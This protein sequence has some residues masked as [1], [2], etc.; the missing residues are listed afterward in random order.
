MTLTATVD[1]SS[2]TG[3]IT[4]YDGAVVLGTSTLSAGTAV[5]FVELNAT[6][7][8][9]MTA[10]YPGDGQNSPALSSPATVTVSSVSA[11]GFNSSNLDVGRVPF[12]TAVGDFNND[13]IPHL[14]TVGSGNSVH[15]GRRLRRDGYPD[16]LVTNSAGNNVTVLRN[17]GTGAFEGWQVFPLGLRLVRDGGRFQWGWKAGFCCSQQ[18]KRQLERVARKR[19]PHFPCGDELPNFA[20]TEDG[21]RETLM[22]TARWIWQSQVTTTR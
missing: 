18:R 16:L 20:S 13:G 14:V 5:L 22:V 1:P 10:R 6:G 19:E 3:K 12:A 4:F 11:S 8:L 7:S 17:D 9:S 15:R 21:L 2:A